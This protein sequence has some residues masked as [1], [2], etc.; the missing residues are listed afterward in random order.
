MLSLLLALLLGYLIIW[1]FSAMA[2]L[3]LAW[4]GLAPSEAVLCRSID[5]FVLYT[6]LVLWLLCAHRAVRNALWLAGVALALRP[7]WML[8]GRAL[9]FDSV[10]QAMQWAHRVLGLEG[11]L[12]LIAF[13]GS[14]ARYDCELDSWMLPTL[15][16]T[17]VAALLSLDQQVS[18]RVTALS[19][20]KTLLQ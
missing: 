10:R 18:L 6:A 19:E 15:R 2:A 14:L 1:P 11:A 5:T 8:G 12:L 9:M 20:G 13:M 16:V 17:P 7:C 3:A 4:L